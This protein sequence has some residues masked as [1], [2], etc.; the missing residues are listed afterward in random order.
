[1][2]DQEV[3]HFTYALYP[4]TGDFRE[5]RVTQEAYA[6]N[7]PLEGE[8]VTGVKTLSYSLLQ[9][10]TENVFADVVKQAEDNSDVII[11]VY[12]GYGKRTNVTMTSPYFTKEVFECNCVE[13]KEE[14]Q[15]V[16]N[17]SICFE[18]KP[19]EIKTFRINR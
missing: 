19:Y 5:G 17:E 1:M 3:H 16:A 14:K 13:E 7:C 15:K 12:E 6:L 11:R 4:H 9:L 18:I 10:D 8:I 2:A